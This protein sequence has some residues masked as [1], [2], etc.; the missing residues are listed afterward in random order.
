MQVVRIITI[1]VEILAHLPEISY[2]HAKDVVVSVK[3]GKGAGTKQ[4]A[5]MTMAESWS[6]L[7]FPTAQPLT[8]MA[9]QPS[10]GQRLASAGQMPSGR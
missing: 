1:C 9:M 10:Q 6:G 8:S 2:A 5:P 7:K 3:E 4:P